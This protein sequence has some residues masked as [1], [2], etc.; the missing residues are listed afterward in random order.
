[1]P[2]RLLVFAGSLRRESWNRKLALI[3]ADAAREQGA[4]VDWADLRE[5]D[6]P[7]YDADVQTTSGL[8]PGAQELVRRVRAA[9][10]LML[11]SPEYNHSIPGGLKNAIDWLSRERPMPTLGKTLLLLGTS[12]GA[13]GAVR[14]LMQTRI[15]FECI[16]VHVY[17]TLFTLPWGDKAFTAEGRLA[18]PAVHQRLGKLV[19]SYLEFT[20]RVG[21]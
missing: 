4:E 20:A 11:A 6:M 17:P 8:P 13:Y 16:G 3:A 14:G 7:L 5:F 12:N 1:M 9:H 10:G 19:G 2:S 21:R 15:V 18:D